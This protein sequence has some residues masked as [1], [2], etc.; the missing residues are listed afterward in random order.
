MLPGVR[1][2]GISALEPVTVLD[3]ARLRT[4][5]HRS[6]RHLR[7]VIGNNK[8]VNLMCALVVLENAAA[9]L[10]RDVLNVVFLLRLERISQARTALNVLRV[11]V[12]NLRDFI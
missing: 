12:P 2:G 4:L 11:V 8:L 10:I 6:A 3:M 5:A 7:P 1:I 9:R